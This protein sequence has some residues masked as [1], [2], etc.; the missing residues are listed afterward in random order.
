MDSIAEFIFVFNDKASSKWASEFPSLAYSSVLLQELMA[1]V[2]WQWAGP[3]GPS[4]SLREA[5]SSAE[6]KLVGCG[7]WDVGGQEGKEKWSLFSYW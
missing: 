2:G 1:G 7:G 5:N 4:I 6:G 3:R